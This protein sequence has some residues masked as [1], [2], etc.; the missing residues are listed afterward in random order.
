M[1]REPTSTPDAASIPSRANG[2]KRSGSG[3]T[4]YSSAEPWTLAAKPGPPAA[5][6][7]PARARI[8]GPITRWFASAAS[9]GPAASITLRTA[10]TFASTYRSTSASLICAKVLTSKPA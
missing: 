10:A 5:A 7:S 6:P 4:V 2:R 1:C 9:G 8:A 3:F